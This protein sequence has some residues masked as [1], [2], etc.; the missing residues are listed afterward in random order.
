MQRGSQP[1]KDSWRS[2]ASRIFRNPLTRRE[3]P[4]QQAES[5]KSAT[6]PLVA[7]PNSPSRSPR[8][9]PL[10]LATRTGSLSPIDPPLLPP[11]NDSSLPSAAHRSL[12]TINSSQDVST[13][14]QNEDFTFSFQWP[15][16]W[17]PTT[18]NAPQ[19]KPATGS[20]EP[21]DHAG[22]L[23]EGTKIK[24][25][26]ADLPTRGQ[27]DFGDSGISSELSLSS[28]GAKY[29][30]K[31]PSPALSIST[32][33]G[34]YREPDS[35]PNALWILESKEEARKSKREQRRS[36]QK[37][38]KRDKQT[39][40]PSPHTATHSLQTPKAVSTTSAPPSKADHQPV[41]KRYNPNPLERTWKFI[42]RLYDVNFP[43]A[44]RISV[45]KWIQLS[46][47]H[48]F[49]APTPRVFVP[50]QEPTTATSEDVDPK[51]R[52][53]HV[54]ELKRQLLRFLSQHLARFHRLKNRAFHSMVSDWEIRGG[55]RDEKA[56]PLVMDY[57]KLRFAEIVLTR[58]I[59]TLKVECDK[60]E[61]EVGK[62]V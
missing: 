43:H 20:N 49:N 53:N 12:S 11:I 38:K 22:E 26:H 47:E 52:G 27:T 55:A 50:W 19:D 3:L 32:P 35:L 25:R 8:T 7:P 48:G 60:L 44:Q 28:H 58:R 14:R 1:T 15:S 6:R 24:I 16:N 40:D 56:V 59:E 62:C 34:Y 36:R 18:A 61:N 21:Q 9:S 4:D 33:H 39:R 23:E 37:Q 31:L 45:D 29:D 5:N 54:L 13:S 17:P 2:R 10:L 42:N 57:W 46:L 51:R 30:L 41:S